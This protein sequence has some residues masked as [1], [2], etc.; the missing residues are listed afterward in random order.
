VIDTCLVV[1]EYIP[2]SNDFLTLEEDNLVYVFSKDPAVTKKEG[3]WL[4]E[5]KQVVGIFP[6]SYGKIFEI[7]L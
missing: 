3:Y 1:R 6:K 5:T 4:G 7:L 2:E